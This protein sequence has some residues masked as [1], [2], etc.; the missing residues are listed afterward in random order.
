LF[1][2]SLFP[3]QIDRR[4]IADRIS[5]V[6]SRRGNRP[7]VAEKLAPIRAITPE[8]R[9]RQLSTASSKPQ[10]KMARAAFA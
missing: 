8:F 5:K 10:D 2:Q 9:L 3:L 6:N 4:A 1:I 7:I